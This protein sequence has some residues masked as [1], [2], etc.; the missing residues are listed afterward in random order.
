M[1]GKERY[2][3]GY[4]RD[5]F[6]DF[7]LFCTSDVFLWQQYLKSNNSMLRI[8][9]NESHLNIFIFVCKKFV[10]QVKVRQDY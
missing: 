4:L 8:Q 3:L 2:V 10:Y 6:F 1:V 5:Y 7:E 9:S